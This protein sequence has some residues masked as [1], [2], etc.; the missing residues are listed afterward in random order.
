MD[1]V[2]QGQEMGAVVDGD[3]GGHRPEARWREAIANACSVLSLCA[4]SGLRACA[5]SAVGSSSTR[6]VPAST[7]EVTRPCSTPMSSSGVA[8]MRPAMSKVQQL[9]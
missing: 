6:Y 1:D 2:G 5:I 4:L 3:V 9:G 8:P 7:R